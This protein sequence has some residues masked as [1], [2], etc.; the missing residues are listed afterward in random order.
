M[1]KT[2]LHGTVYSLITKALHVTVKKPL[3]Y[4]VFLFWARGNNSN[5]RLLHPAYELDYVTKLSD[6][7]W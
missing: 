5:L 3:C 6:E 7:A 1:K 2:V 4:I